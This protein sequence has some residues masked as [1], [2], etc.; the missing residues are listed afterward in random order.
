MSSND[1]TKP[2]LKQLDLFH[3]YQKPYDNDLDVWLHSSYAKVISD[4]LA[5]DWSVV[6]FSPS[7][8][9]VCPRALYEKAKKSKKD[10]YKPQPH[11][12][13]WTSTGEK[14]GDMLQEEFLLCE[15]HLEKFSGVKPRFTMGIT[16][17]GYPAFEQFIWTQKRVEHNGE[18]FYLTGTG[19]G[20]LVDN[21]TGK[22]IGLEIK[23]K[24]QTPSKTS[25]RAMT[26]PQ[27]SH[28]KQV[29][30]YSIMYDVDTFVIAYYNTAKKGWFLTDEEYEKTPD[31][32]LFQV[33]ISDE[34]KTDILDF[35]ADITRRVREN[36]PPLPDLTKWK[37]N[38][39][40]DAI[41]KSITAEEIA[42]LETI[43]DFLIEDMQ[44]WERR[45]VLESLDDIKRRFAE[46]SV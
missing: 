46:R 33:D 21:E 39:F 5:V 34:D 16:D 25:I 36:D 7:S 26:A 37:F 28:V 27:E 20:L 40:K 42:T 19:D 9:N 1:L 23:S 43:A 18:V 2:I 44:A 30:S 32:R 38:D 10:I 41:G 3:S 17:K 12:R 24:Q 8:A 4:G 6:Y 29:I 45:S 15:R 31:L 22:T 13:R 11:Q 35:F 14:I